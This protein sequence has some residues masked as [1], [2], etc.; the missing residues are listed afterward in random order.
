[1]DGALLVQNNRGLPVHVVERKM[2][3]SE[4]LLP[5]GHCGRCDAWC[6]RRAGLLRAA[7][8]LHRVRNVRLRT[9]KLRAPGFHFVKRQAFLQRGFGLALQG[10]VDRRMHRVGLGGQALDAI[11]LRLA[12]DVI[13]KVET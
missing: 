3:G 9:L 6:G 11:R 2:H 4:R 10:C 1:M 12:A 7:E 13:D 8:F 5:G